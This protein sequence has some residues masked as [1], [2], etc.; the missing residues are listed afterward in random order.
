L[1]QGEKKGK[2]TAGVG[3]L[4]SL[5]ELKLNN[6]TFREKLLAKPSGDEEYQR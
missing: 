6:C 5:I 2:A 3:S 1:A 4:K